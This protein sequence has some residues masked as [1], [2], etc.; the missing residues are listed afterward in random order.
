MSYGGNQHPAQVFEKTPYGTYKSIKTGTTNNTDMIPIKPIQ[1]GID[2]SYIKNRPFEGCRSD[3]GNHEL[4]GLAFN[5][6]DT[7]IIEEVKKRRPR[8]SKRAK[9]KYKK[10]PSSD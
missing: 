4:V 8:L 6:I 7:P 1:K 3:Y 10:M 9:E 5:P 2:C